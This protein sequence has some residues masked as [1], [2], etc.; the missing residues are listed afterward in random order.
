MSTDSK[1][2]GNKKKSS[3]S[4]AAA[5]PKSKSTS[6][7][8]AAPTYDDDVP[9]FS[10]V[11]PP[12]SDSK[13]ETK[14]IQSIVPPAARTP[15]Q[16]WSGL[17]EGATSTTN[18]TSATTTTTTT[19]R[20]LIGGA[21]EP[22]KR[23]RLIIPSAMPSPPEDKPFVTGANFLAAQKGRLLIGGPPPVPG[24]PPTVAAASS[25]GPISAGPYPDPSVGNARTWPPKETPPW[26]QHQTTATYLVDQK[27]YKRR[28]AEVEDS[29]RMCPLGQPD[30]FTLFQGEIGLTMDLTQLPRSLPNNPNNPQAYVFSVLNGL[31]KGTRMSVAGVI[32]QSTRMNGFDT[33]SVAVL[34]QGTA[35]ISNFGAFEILEG[36]HVYVWDKPY[37]LSVLKANGKDTEIVPRNRE[38]N[39]SASK[40]L[41]VVYAIEFDHP[42]TFVATLTDQ[43]RVGLDTLDQRLSLNEKMMSVKATIDIWLQ[44]KGFMAS[45]PANIL[46]YW[47][48]LHE[49][50]K[51]ATARLLATLFD[52]EF[53]KIVDSIRE[54]IG[55]LI[56]TERYIFEIGK[57]P[58]SYHAALATADIGATSAVTMSSSGVITYAKPDLVHKRNDYWT[59]LRRYVEDRSLLAYQTYVDYQSRMYL[60]RANSTA[61]VG[62][63]FTVELG[64]KP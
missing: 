4:A 6:A 14:R 5:A 33:P 54:L 51:F 49:L 61:P 19:K 22:L 58:D 63:S 8:A 20:P 27:D 31:R 1:S 15:A 37:F 12:P 62:A 39:V 40:F 13:R 7:A 32:N 47:I 38:I 3:S 9:S 23:R 26:I 43:I 17:V 10:D 29:E 34:K 48:T 30:D 60:G 18:T 35:V 46:A 50:V 44:A 59:K 41:A 11:T 42:F 57:E 45:H 64:L 52:D 36:Q 28:A 25:S 53:I 55:W 24:V 2:G 16:G 56:R 21:A